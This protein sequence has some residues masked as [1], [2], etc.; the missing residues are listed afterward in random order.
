MNYARIAT[1]VI[2]L[3]MLQ[4]PTVFAQ[5]ASSESGG[6]PFQMSGGAQ[7]QAKNNQKTG[8]KQGQAVTHTHTVRTTTTTTHK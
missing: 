6:V 4:C 7:I 3:G 1:A 8:Q 5:E 2:A